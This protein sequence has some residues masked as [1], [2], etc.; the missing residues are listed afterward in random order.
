MLQILVAEFKIFEVLKSWRK[1]GVSALTLFL[2]QLFSTVQ[3]RNGVTT[4]KK[5]KKKIT[6][7]LINRDLDRI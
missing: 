2:C 1:K 7:C 4:K 6:N 3:D 5:K